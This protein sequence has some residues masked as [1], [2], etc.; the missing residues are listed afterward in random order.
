[1]MNNAQVFNFPICV[2]FQPPNLLLPFFYHSHFKVFAGRQL[3]LQWAEN[4]K[5][6]FNSPTS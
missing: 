5:L 4:S 2:F 1:M 6:G 3:V